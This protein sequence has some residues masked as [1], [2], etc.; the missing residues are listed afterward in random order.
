[1]NIKKNRLP[2]DT[3]N[4]VYIYIGTLHTAMACLVFIKIA[5]AFRCSI[6]QTRRPRW[7]VYV[8]DQA[9]ITDEGYGNDQN[10][11]IRKHQA[12]WDRFEEMKKIPRTIR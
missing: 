9:R 2:T 11:G 1:M 8:N 6:N 7:C 4:C 12:S 10:A 3:H 5:N